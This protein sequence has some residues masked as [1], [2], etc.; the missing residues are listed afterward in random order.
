MTEPMRNAVTPRAEPSGRAEREVRG[1]K[2]LETGRRPDVV[3]VKTDHDRLRA[4]L[5]RRWP[6]LH[7]QAVEF[8]MRKLDR[9][10]VVESAELPPGTVTMYSVVE[11]RDEAD[12]AARVAQLVYPGEERFNDNGLSVLTPAGAALIG[13]R[14]GQSISYLADG[15]TRKTITILKILYQPEAHL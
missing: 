14:E 2:P 5:V 11:Y 10:T 7:W 12:G 6:I 13:Q 3:L 15:G 9:A 4:R 8:L 1:E